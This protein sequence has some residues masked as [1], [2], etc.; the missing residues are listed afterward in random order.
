MEVCAVPDSLYS[1]RQIPEASFVK[2]RELVSQLVANYNSAGC[3][4]QRARQRLLWRLSN[5]T[6]KQLRPTTR[7]RSVLPTIEER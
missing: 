5:R 2:T 3:T 7:L 6:M 4:P 1:P